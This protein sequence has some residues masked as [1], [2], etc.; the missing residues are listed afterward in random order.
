MTQ[1]M[2]FA[3]DLARRAGELGLKYFRELDTL[4][5]ESK[6]HQ[7]LVSDGDR[8]VELFVR[9][10]I[11]AELSRRRHRRRGACRRAGTSGYV[12]VID[13]IDGTAN[14]VRGIPAWCVVIA[15]AKDGVTDVGVIHEPS[16]GETFH[17]RRGGGAFLNGKPIKA[18]CGDRA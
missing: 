2:R 11:G 3:T 5:I 9:A 4:T 15:C 12:W 6:G 13:P 8:E 1:R 14:F 7:D 17:G 18:S 10:A 16:T